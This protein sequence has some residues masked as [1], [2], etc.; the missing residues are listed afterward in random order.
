MRP[1]DAAADLDVV[2]FWQEEARRRLGKRLFFASDE[3]YLVAG[4]P[5]PTSAEYEG[6]DQH[7]NG[8]G[9]I[10]A[11]HDELE[12]AESGRK[13]SFPVA[14]G[15]WSAVPAAPAEG[16]R[17]RRPEIHTG[18][19]EEG[20]VVIVTGDYGARVLAEVLPRLESLAGESLRVLPVSND[21]FGGNVAVAGLLV[22][23]DVAAAIAADSLPARKYLIPNTAVPGG[24]FLDDIDIV[25]IEAPIDAVP[26]TVAGLLSGAMT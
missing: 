24:R 23:A 8:I 4:R 22:G 18:S 19:T 21:Y 11:F 25:D 9:M 5:V 20:P 2:A 15:A 16:Y 6:F 14:T 10:R 1:E 26:P 12:A 13:A 7:E 17:E 3:M